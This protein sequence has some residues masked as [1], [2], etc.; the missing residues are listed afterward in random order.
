[1]EV[2]PV[3]RVQQVNVPPMI[4]KSPPSMRED[5]GI[6]NFIHAHLFSGV[7][8]QTLQSRKHCTKCME[9]ITPTMPMKTSDEKSITAVGSA[10]REKTFR[11]FPVRYTPTSMDC[12]SERPSGGGRSVTAHNVPAVEQAQR[13]FGRLGKWIGGKVAHRTKVNEQRWTRSRR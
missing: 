12:G 10:E 3:E 4:K 8:R 1:M 13:L 6:A 7:S 9:E 5:E 2:P 11:V